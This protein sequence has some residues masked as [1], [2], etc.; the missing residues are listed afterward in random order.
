MVYLGNDNYQPTS[1]EFEVQQKYHIAADKA[2]T[3][4]EYRAVLKATGCKGSYSLMKLE[5]HDPQRQVSL[6]L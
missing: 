1:K 2:K 4:G 3:K 6:Y 5:N